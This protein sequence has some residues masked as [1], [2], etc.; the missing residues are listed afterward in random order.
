MNSQ[1]PAVQSAKMFIV[2]ALFTHN[3]A[4]T[5][6]IEED[7][8]DYLKQALYLTRTP[9]NGAFEACARWGRV[10]I[11]LTALLI[12][13]SPWT[14]YYWHFDNFLRG[15]QDFE[16]GLL[17]T[18]MVFCLVLVLLQ[19]PK[20]GATF[21]SALCR[22]LSVVFQG[23]DSALPGLSL[24]SVMAYEAVPLLSPTLGVYD[25]PLRI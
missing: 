14:E 5:S 1:K 19:D 24:R 21:L 16:F 9:W 8:E 15:G 20:H 10:L 12:S 13:I 6:R 7:R 11:A 4:G 3:S 22:W 23:R 25:F 2:L 17:T 18:I